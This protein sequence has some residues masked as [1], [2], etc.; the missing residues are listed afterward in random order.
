VSRRDRSSAGRR[1]ADLFAARPS[2]RRTEQRLTAVTHDFAEPAEL[3]GF[4][5]SVGR[6]AHAGDARF[7]ATVSATTSWPDGPHGRGSTTPTCRPAV[8][9]SRGRRPRQA[10]TPGKTG[11]RLADCLVQDIAVLAPPISKNSWSP[12]IFSALPNR[13]T[14]APRSPGPHREGSVHRSSARAALRR[15]GG[16]GRDEPRAHGVRRACRDPARQPQQV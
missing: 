13:R 15:C 16:Q 7:S 12:W 8:V 9:E 6:Q 11:V 5:T 14:S 1:P 10:L 2:P 4:T 3:G